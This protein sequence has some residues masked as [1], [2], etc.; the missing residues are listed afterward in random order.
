MSRISFFLSLVTHTHH[1]LWITLKTFCSTYE[2][3]WYTYCTDEESEASTPKWVQQAGHLLVLCHT[4][5]QRAAESAQTDVYVVIRNRRTVNWDM[6][7]M[8]ASRVHGFFQNARH[9]FKPPA[10][11]I[12]SLLRCGQKRKTRVDV[13]LCFLNTLRYNLKMACRRTTRRSWS[14]WSRVPPWS[15]YKPP[16][17][18]VELAI[19]EQEECDAAGCQPGEPATGQRDY[20]ASLWKWQC[21]LLKYDQELKGHVWII[22]I[23]MPLMS[24]Q[25]SCKG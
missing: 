9:L 5:F 17:T 23:C 12:D 19:M 3:H 6:M 11:W 18:W 24:G 21:L 4:T 25:R 8:G 14:A 1:L 10:R 16:S 7:A 2:G 15:N 20:S 22:N 13:G